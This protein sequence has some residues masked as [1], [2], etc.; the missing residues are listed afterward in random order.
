MLGAAW[1]YHASKRLT[2]RAPDVA[3]APE[4][5]AVAPASLNPGLAE[6]PGL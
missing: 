2:W 6:G 3:A 5:A 4:A 1:N